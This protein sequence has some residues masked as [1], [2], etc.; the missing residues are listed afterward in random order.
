M[1]D[2]ADALRTIAPH[3]F[4]HI[5]VMGLVFAAADA[6]GIGVCAR[7]LHCARTPGCGADARLFLDVC[8]QGPMT[9]P[10]VL[11]RPWAPARCR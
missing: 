5:F 3:S 4:T 8:V 9:L 10:T 1:A 11:R 7:A 6:F 2:T